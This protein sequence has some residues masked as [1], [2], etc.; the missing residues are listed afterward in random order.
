ME[1][2]GITKKHQW[3]DMDMLPFLP[4]KGATDKTKYENSESF[5]EM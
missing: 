5:V 4:E 2:T 1:W 3:S